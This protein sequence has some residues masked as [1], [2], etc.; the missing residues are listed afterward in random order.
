M[1]EEE[2][3]E[4]EGEGEGEKGEEGEEGYTFKSCKAARSTTMNV[5]NG[6]GDTARHCTFQKKC[7]S[8]SL[9][10]HARTHNTQEHQQHLV[11]VLALQVF[12]V[13]E[14]ELRCRH[15]QDPVQQGHGVVD[16][17]GSFDSFLHGGLGSVGQLNGM[18]QRVDAVLV[19]GRA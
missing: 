10:Y 5:S 13:P 6:K 12:H 14:L 2:E 7:R 18:V 16:A 3:E 11:A 4:E 17:F 15:L 19:V 1:K 9:V 8:Y